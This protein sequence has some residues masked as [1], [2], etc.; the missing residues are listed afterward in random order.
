MTMKKHNKKLKVGAYLFAACVR[1]DSYFA[2]IKR[3]IEKAANDDI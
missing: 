2:A 3:G 1:I